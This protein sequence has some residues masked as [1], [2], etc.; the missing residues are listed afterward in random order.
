M[1]RIRQIKPSFFINE[2]LADCSA[3]A[4]LCFIGLWGIADREGRMEDRPRKI[5][6]EI[7]PYDSWEVESLLADLNRVGMI[8]RYEVEGRRYIQIVNFVKHQKPHPKE[9]P[10]EIPPPPKTEEAQDQTTAGRDQTEQDEEVTESREKVRLDME[11]PE[12]V[13]TSRVGNGLWVMGNGERGMGNG[14]ATPGG[15]SETRARAGEGEA[16]ANPPPVQKVLQAVA[17]LTKTDLDQ[18]SISRLQACGS[19]VEFV[20]ARFPRE[21]DEARAARVYGFGVWFQCRGMPNP[22]PTPRQVIDDW[23][24]YE[25]SEKESSQ[26]GKSKRAFTSE[27]DKYAHLTE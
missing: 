20:E 2:Q 27:P 15:V 16:L 18:C 21:T 3:E 23:Q 12:K 24:L 9:L 26:S 14:S 5:K 8:V 4:R 1:A 6:A 19:V 11:K 7:F 13:C 25:A 22:T 17:E 10:S